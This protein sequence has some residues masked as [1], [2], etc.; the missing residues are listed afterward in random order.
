MLQEIGQ[1]VVLLLVQCVE[2]W[3]VCIDNGEKG[4]ELKVCVDCE[5]VVVFG[6][7]VEQVVSFVGLVLCGVLMC[8]FCRGDNEVLVWVCFVG[9]EQS[10]LEDLVGFSVCI[11]DGCS[12]LLLSLVIV[13]VGLL[14]IQ[15]GCINCQMML[16]IKVNLVEK[17]I[18]LDGCKVI[19][20]VFKLMNFLVGYGFI[21]DGGD[22]GNDDEVMQQMVFNL[23]IVL[24]M[25]YVV[26]V[27]VFELLLFLVVIMS[28]V[29]FL[30]FGV[31]WLFWII[32]ILF[33][34]MFFIG[35]LVLM[36][37][38][39]N[40]GIVMI[41]YINNLWCSGMGCIQVLVEGLC[42]CLCLIMMIMG[43]VILVMVLI[44]L[45]D[46][47]MFG[48]GLEYLLMVCVIVGGLVFLIVVS[49]LFLLM[50]YV[51]FDDL[52]NVVMWLICCVCGV[53]MV[54]LGVVWL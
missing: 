32:G 34:I 7:N 40:N 20:V 35:I 36:G 43:M 29:L 44:L 10:S 37:V 3:D 11:G 28:G 38:V 30:I 13:D 45:I 26:M 49:L 50:I 22:Y 19:E 1:E 41:E 24:V 48:N 33:G 27:V 39:V 18:V 16:I 17:V 54:E 12:V 4:G 8:E 31:F 14:V 9:V 47:Q 25:I 51:V 46:M 42:E 53:E 5:C 23:L 15:I 6:F 52:C 21:F 2:L